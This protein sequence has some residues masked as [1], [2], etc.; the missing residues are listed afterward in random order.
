MQRKQK[1]KVWIQRWKA[2]IEHQ[3]FKSYLI[4][5]RGKTS[6]EFKKFV[7]DFFKRNK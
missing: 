3:K 5:K 1:K 7:K 4:N 6:N 2:E